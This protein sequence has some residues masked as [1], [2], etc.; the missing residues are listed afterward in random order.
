[1]GFNNRFMSIHIALMTCGFASPSFATS[2]NNSNHV[3]PF[4]SHFGATLGGSLDL[5]SLQNSD[6]GLISRNMMAYSFETLLGYKLSS[7]LLG[8]HLNYRWQDQLTSLESAGGTNLRGSDL[9]LGIGFRYNF[10]RAWSLQTAIDFIGNYQFVRK[11]YASEDASISSPIALRLKAQYLFIPDLLSADINVNL[12]H[13]SVFRISSTD[14]S[15]SSMSIMAGIGLTWHFGDRVLTIESDMQPTEELE[16]VSQ[17]GQTPALPALQILESQ[18]NQVTEVK[19]TKQ[20][21]MIN[22]QGD[23]SFPSGSSELSAK[24]VETIQKIGST[25][26]TDPS[27]KIRIEGY[28]DSAGNAN[29]NMQLSKARAEQVKQILINQG[30]H[31]EN[32]SAE[33][34]G[35][36]HPISNNSTIEGRAKNRRVE[37]YIDQ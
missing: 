12:I 18:L 29:K 11:T 37:I 10:S 6:A 36:D 9:L 13:Y 16:P 24:A 23:L 32:I 8:I 7:W 30:V 2:E 15:S 17:L 31:A 26:L 20:G 33:G 25:L 14:Y 5:G 28:T 34:F 19:H 3:S 22:L 27:Q 35:Q 21:L 4:L 1:M